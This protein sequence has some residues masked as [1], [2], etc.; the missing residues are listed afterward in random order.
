M[1]LS[2]NAD[3]SIHIIKTNKESEGHS[4]KTST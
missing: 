4:I 1:T 2:N 3:I